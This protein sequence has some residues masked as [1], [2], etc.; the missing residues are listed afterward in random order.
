MNAP[1]DRPDTDVCE[2]AAP[3]A[4]SGS[5]IAWI[6]ATKVPH[7]RE[8]SAARVVAAKLRARK[9]IVAMPLS[10]NAVSARCKAL[11]QWQKLKR[12]HDT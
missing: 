4:G 10:K 5:A 7:S 8:N 9:V 1:D 3:S 11:L 6:G 2:S 12:V